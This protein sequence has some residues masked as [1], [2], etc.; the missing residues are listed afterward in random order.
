[1]I[2][3]FTLDDLYEFFVDQG[4][5]FSYNSQKD[6]AE[7]YVQIPNTMT[8]DS[9]Y[10]PTSNLLMTHLRS[11]HINTNRN[12][13]SI[14]QEAMEQAIPSFYNRPILG[15]IHQLSDGSYDFAGHE[16][17]IDNDGKIE[18]QEIPIGH[19]PE[20]CNAKLVYDEEKDK[21]YLELDGVIYEDYTRAADIL[22]EK[23]ESKVSVEICVEEMS[24]SAKERVL[25]IEK[26]RFNGVTILGKSIDTEE[27]I[28]EGMEGSNITLA[29]FS[30]EKNSIFDNDLV[31]VLEKL[32]NTLANFN[33]SVKEGGQELDKFKQLCEKYHVNVEDIEFE[34]EG[35]EDEELEAKF[36][37]VFDND[38]SDPEPEDITEN[39]EDDIDD[40]EDNIDDHGD[41]DE[42]DDS[43]HTEFSEDLVKS[44]KVSHDD[45]RC[46]LYN[47]VAVY[48]SDSTWIYIREVYNDEF[49]M[50]ECGSE[51]KLYK[52]A[53]VVDGDNVSLSGDRIEVFEIYVTESEK[54]SLD[55]MRENYADLKSY[56]ENAESE[57]IKSKKFDILAGYEDDLADCKEFTE[58]KENIDSVDLEKIAE[59]CDAIYGRHMKHVY[60]EHKKENKV[61]FGL[62][63]DDNSED[64]PYGTLFDE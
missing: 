20:S 6:K 23:K 37:E 15:Y 25:V 17:T 5:S 35:L 13:S 38:E 3:L 24:Y 26:F 64:K 27:P 14:P 59:K 63:Q 40:P 47:L 44:F 51:H 41:G 58:L 34:Y 21:T 22:R 2:K 7:I 50:E 39:H 46:A 29:D 53:Y 43:E 31:N 10:D 12:S 16:M 56:K 11:C 60:A 52:Q 19:I 9:D 48:E 36:A 61:S 54:I 33:K 28:S 42:P 4:K 8:F 49:I 45:I 32:N 30:R 18:Y 55:E 1:M 57:K 62:H